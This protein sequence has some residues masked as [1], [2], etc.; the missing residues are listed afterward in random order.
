[1]LRLIYNESSTAMKNWIDYYRSMN[2]KFLI[3]ALL[4][5]A[6]NACVDIDYGDRE[7]NLSVGDHRKT[8]FAIVSSVV[9]KKVCKCSFFVSYS[10]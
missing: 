3:L 7:G 9:Y 4:A 8:A 6:C 5:L 1:M 10:V 2:R